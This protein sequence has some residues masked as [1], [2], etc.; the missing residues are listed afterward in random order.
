M[1]AFGDRLHMA[2]RW[3]VC[4]MQAIAAHVPREGAIIDLGCGHGLFTQ[5]LARQS[6]TRTVI[7]VD[8]D[9]HK[10]ALASSLH[11]KLPNL[12][13]E[14]G[15]II[16]LAGS[17]PSAQCVTILDVF[18]LVP[19][20]AQE[21]ILRVCAE[22]LAA[23]GVLVLK[24]MAETP[25]WKAW[26]N[27]AEE[28]LVVRWLKITAT[29]D[30]EAAFYFRRRAEWVALLERFGLTVVTVPLDRGYYHPHVLFVASK[31]ASS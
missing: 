13:F 22:K 12:R 19:H 5:L 11:G 10:I 29:S 30:S 28:T 31:A 21:V 16:D 1:L 3:L 9:R 14:A 27:H 24:D 18:Y 26:L 6:P 15:D 4:P 17:L 25:R 20:A 8:L 23:G 7:G 2:I